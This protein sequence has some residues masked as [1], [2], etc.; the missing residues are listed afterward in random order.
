[1]WGAKQLAAP[2]PAV[3]RRRRSQA[4]AW[5]QEEGNWVGKRRNAPASAARAA[6]RVG[7]DVA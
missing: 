2:R 3:A 5:V 4:I 1:M 6:R 7:D